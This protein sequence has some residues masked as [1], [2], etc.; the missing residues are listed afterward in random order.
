MK[1]SL[2]IKIFIISAFIFAAGYLTAFLLCMSNDYSSNYIHTYKG[3]DIKEVQYEEDSK[4]V[5][6]FFNNGKEII[7]N[8]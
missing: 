7:I 4:I 1:T 6:I 3:T 8:E 5:R 2:F